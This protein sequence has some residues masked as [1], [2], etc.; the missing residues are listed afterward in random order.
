ML[1]TVFMI[2]LVWAVASVPLGLAVAAVLK[3]TQPACTTV[4]KL[5][6]YIEFLASRDSA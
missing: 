5:E 2:L 3:L 4:V 1:L 6:D